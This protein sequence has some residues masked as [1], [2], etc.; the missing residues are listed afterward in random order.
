[1]VM[2]FFAVE[3]AQA[4]PFSAM[5]FEGGAQVVNFDLGGAYYWRRD[6]FNGYSWQIKSGHL[7]A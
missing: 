6:R 7:S 2:P 4:A 3:E 5:L 1:M